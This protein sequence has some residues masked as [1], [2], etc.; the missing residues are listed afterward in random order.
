MPNPSITEPVLPAPTVIP[1]PL[2]VASAT[3]VPP[4]EIQR[5]ISFASWWAGQYSSPSADEALRAIAELGANWI[6]LIVTGHQDTAEA[7]T[8]SWQPP[9]TPSD[10][11]L[12]HAV[13]TAHRL[14]LSVMLKPHVDLLNDDA[15]WR[16]DIGKA[17]RSEETW[18]AWFA[19][20]QPAIV[21]YATLAQTHGVEQFCVGT[22][23]V[24]LSDRSAEWR[25]IVRAVRDVFQGSVV[26][27]SNHDGEEASVDWWDAV[28]YI[29]VDAYYSLSTK[30]NPTVA[31]LKRAW[32]EKEYV[33]LLAGLAARYGKPILFTEIGYRSITGATEQPW[34]WDTYAEPAPN[35]QANAYQAAL[36]TFSNEPWLAGYFWWDWTTSQ[37]QGGLAD[38]DYTPVGKPAEKILRDFY[39]RLAKRTG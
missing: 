10:D 4:P 32:F 15:H 37:F 16:G 39:T 8:I 38:T 33:S 31:E 13:D 17:F 21:R 35:E 5:G 27:A 2:T 7:T 29:G 19:S 20:Y 1:T 22:E 23:L 30:A 18:R 14:G 26:Y 28:D 25:A 24:N 34:V 3:P 6:S 36:E 9:H 11:D 12:I